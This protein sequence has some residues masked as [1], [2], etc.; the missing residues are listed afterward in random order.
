[1]SEPDRVT[2]H[3]ESVT[4]VADGISTMYSQ[5]RTKPR[6]LALLT[7][8]LN[9]AQ[10]FENAAWAVLVDTSLDTAEDA[11]LDQVGA[12]L[13]FPR[14]ALPNDDTYRRVLR[15]VVRCHS[16]NGT[17]ND[18]MEIAALVLGP[19]FEFTYREAHASILITASGPLPVDPAVVHALLMTAKAGGVQLQITSPPRVITELFTLSS[20]PFRPVTS[21]SLGFSNV[22][23]DTGG[24]LNGVV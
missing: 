22:A 4:H 24:H 23:E 18:V 3:T 6:L 15:A 16:S 12:V 11:A 20:D 10:E 2:E 8:Y 9:R 17:G 7:A 19:T 14:G 1:M 5:F 13:L 21:A